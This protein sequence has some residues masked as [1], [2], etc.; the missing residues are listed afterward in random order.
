[1]AIGWDA[2]SA[3]VLKY[4]PFLREGA[5]TTEKQV[6]LWVKSVVGNCPSFAQIDNFIGETSA[7]LSSLG[8]DGGDIG[9]GVSECGR[10]LNALLDV[11][12]P[13]LVVE[14]PQL[15]RA[16][17]VAVMSALADAS[18]GTITSC[19]PNCRCTFRRTFSRHWT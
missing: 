3:S 7:A 5:E 16:M 15:N 18:A 11:V 19:W 13:D 1:M 8:D 4:R 6:A 9:D 10:K 2:E 17:W 14:S 12:I